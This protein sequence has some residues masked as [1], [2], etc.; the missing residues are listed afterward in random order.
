M[1]VPVRW[2]TE[3]DVTTRPNQELLW[4]SADAAN[5][6]ADR[7]FDPAQILPKCEPVTITLREWLA[8]PGGGL[9]FHS[10]FSPAG[11]ADCALGEHDGFQLV[12]TIPAGCGLPKVHP[13]SAM[14]LPDGLRSGAAHALLPVAPPCSM[15]A[16]DLVCS[17]HRRPRRHC[18]GRE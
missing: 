17:T 15:A 9:T 12:A 3:A 4:A 11:L 5:Q 8:V 7:D 6:L 10:H 16:S 2:P 18:C 13:N 14:A 1:P